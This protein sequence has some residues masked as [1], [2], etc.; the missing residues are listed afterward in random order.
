MVIICIY[1]Y[2][3]IELLYLQCSLAYD[4]YD[5]FF[6]FLFICIFII[7]VLII[8]VSTGFLLLYFFLIFMI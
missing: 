7:I 3:R 5:L 8:I 6:I 2:T 1:I 4:R